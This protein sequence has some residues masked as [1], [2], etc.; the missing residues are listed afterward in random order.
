MKEDLLEELDVLKNVFV[1]NG[2]A[3]QLVTKNLQESWPRETVKA[4]L[5]GVCKLKMERI[6]LRFS[7]KYIKGFTEGLQRRLRNLTI[8]F[9]PKRRETICTNLCKLKQKVEFEDCKDAIYSVPCEKFGARIYWGNLT[10]FLSKK[11]TT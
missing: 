1:R 2:Y 4:V 11:G 8:G 9:V 10:A 7:M 3:E 5:K 6:I